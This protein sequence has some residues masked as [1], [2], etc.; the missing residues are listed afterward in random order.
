MNKKIIALICV[1]LCLVTLTAGAETV[2]GN[3][4]ERFGAALEITH[5]GKTYRLRDRLTT[6]L[7]AGVDQSAETL[8]GLSGEFRSGGQADFQLL[9]VID[10][11]RDTVQTMQINRD[12]MTKITVLNVLGKK[13]GTR[14]AQICLAHAFGDGGELSCEL[15]TE[16]VSNYLM[17]V[18][19]DYY[20][21]VN[22]DGIPA[23]NDVLGGVEVT[24]EEDF[25]AFD[26]E[27][28]AGKTLTLRGEQAELYVRGRIGVGDQ[29]NI[30]RAAR[31]QKYIA[32][33]TER[34]TGR[35]KA[36]VGFVN[37]V[38]A[39]LEPYIVTNLTK[40]RLANIAT[41]AVRCET[42]PAAVVEGEAVLG[43]NGFMEFYPDEASRMQALLEMF[44]EP[45]E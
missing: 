15:L 20:I 35:L 29:T 32:A 2:R 39:A 26:P 37:D 22:L 4:E 45:V 18:P 10:G 12:T 31:Q 40:G 13:S 5:D 16:A 11:E 27:M 41:G 3:L 23:L 1:L 36:S 38:Y 7:V 42:L 25:S 34:M 6:I 14:T 21:C 43:G 8:A 24:L 30:S 9:I 44:F 33:A 17:G 28:T 19:V